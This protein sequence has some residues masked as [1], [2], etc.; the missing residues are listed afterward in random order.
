VTQPH[1]DNWLDVDTT[2]PAGQIYDEFA[3]KFINTNRL[4]IGNVEKVPSHRDYQYGMNSD[5]T[6]NSTYLNLKELEGLLSF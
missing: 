6:I 1:V 5:P 4:G 3:K 2:T